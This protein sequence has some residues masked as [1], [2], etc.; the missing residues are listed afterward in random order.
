MCKENYDEALKRRAAL[1]AA[2]T[3]MRRK[4]PLSSV[5]RADH[6][7]IADD[8]ESRLLCQLLSNLW[9]VNCP[10][11]AHHASSMPCRRQKRQLCR[12]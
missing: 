9:Q 1:P 11:P 6:A 2:C 5:S 8:G 4:P 12:F 7:D 3:G 10:L